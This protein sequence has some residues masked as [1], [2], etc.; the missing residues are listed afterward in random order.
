VD[1]WLLSKLS[2]TVKEVNK[3]FADEYDL[4]RNV[5]ALRRFY[6]TYFFD[7]Y[8]EST[9]PLFRAINQSDKHALA[10]VVWNCMRI[11]NRTMLL[12]YHPFIPSITEELWQINKGFTLDFDV[13]SLSILED[14]YPSDIDF[15]L[16]N[17][18]IL[19]FL[20]IFFFFF[21]FKYFFLK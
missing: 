9:K 11:C 10:E 3:N 19:N 1:V 14:N 16:G 13:N 12:M 8:V 2:E 7:F 21:F 5:K 4:H 15:E 17:V 6:Y 18:S 20:M